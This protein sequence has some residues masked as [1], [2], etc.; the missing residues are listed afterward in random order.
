M[1]AVFSALLFGLL[2]SVS[3]F[4][5]EARKIDE[6]D[7]VPCD[8]YLGRMDNAIAQARENPS[9]K[10]YVLIYEG[11]ESIYNR[12]KNKMELAFPAYGSTEA[13]IRSIK[14]YLSKRKLPIER[15]SFVKAGFR[16]NTALEIWFVMPGAAPPKPAPT[17]KKMRYR[18]GKP[19]GFCTD[20]CGT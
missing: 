13:K 11:K 3:T 19:V 1:K 14:N 15:F 8:E 18:K 20:C 6:F 16:E 10:V 12:R 7:I 17:L 2:L 5:Q 9:A 4:S